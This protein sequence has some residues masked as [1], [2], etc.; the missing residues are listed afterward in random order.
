MSD[1]DERHITDLLSD[2]EKFYTE[3]RSVV[4]QL[5]ITVEALKDISVLN[6]RASNIAKVAL[7]KVE[8]KYK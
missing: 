7:E 1:K 4:G 5:K 6:E 2:N 8:T 3:L